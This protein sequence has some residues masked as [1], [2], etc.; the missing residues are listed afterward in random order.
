MAVHKATKVSRPRIYY[1]LKEIQR[2]GDIG[3]RTRQKAR[4][5]T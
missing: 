3:A 4:R 1:G 2:E 5:R